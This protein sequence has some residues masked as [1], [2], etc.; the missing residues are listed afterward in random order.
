MFGHGSDNYDHQKNYTEADDRADL[1]LSPKNIDFPP[2]IPLMHLM[3]I[4]FG[5]HI[6]QMFKS[7][8]NL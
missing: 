3:D 4:G 2:L 7:D 8:P 1:G 6:M 5:A